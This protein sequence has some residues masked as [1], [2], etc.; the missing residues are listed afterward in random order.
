MPGLPEERIRGPGFHDFAQIHHR[1]TVGQV[2]DHPQV[3]GNEQ[4]G[5]P[6]L[7]LQLL[8]QVDDLCLDGDV[9]GGDG[10]VAD[11]QVRL[12]GEGSRDADPLAL[13]TGELVR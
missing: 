12:E 13:S 11:E 2:P 3:V 10:L 5:E 1:D 9:Q 6:E 4:V 7:L 8:Q